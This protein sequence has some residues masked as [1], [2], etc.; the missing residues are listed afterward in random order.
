[1]IQLVT[2]PASVYNLALPWNYLRCMCGRFFG[3]NVSQIEPLLFVGGEFRAAQWPTLH[4]LGVRAVLSLQAEYEDRYVGPPPERTL[5]LMVPDFHAPSLEQI[6]EGV[7]FLRAVHAEGLPVLVHCHAGVGR[8]PMTAAAYLMA[9]RNLSLVE[10]LTYLRAA[11]PII[12]V[13]GRQLH[14]LREWEQHIQ[15]QSGE[16]D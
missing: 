9:T 8:A 4:A 15:Q 11:R 6:A 2:N 1:M 16:N 10:A 12:G 14:R 13:N 7:A 3:L 5:R